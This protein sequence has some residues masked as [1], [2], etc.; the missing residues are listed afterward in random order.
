MTDLRLSLQF[1]VFITQVPWEEAWRAP[2]SPAAPGRLD[3]YEERERV[4][5]LAQRGFS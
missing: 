1:G 3:S 5:P 2:S 4:D